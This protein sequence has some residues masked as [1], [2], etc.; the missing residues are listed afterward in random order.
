MNRTTQF[1]YICHFFFSL[2]LGN[3]GVLKNFA[4]FTPVLEP[5]FNKVADLQSPVCNFIKKDTSIPTNFAKFEICK[6]T[7]VIEQLL[8][9]F[10]TTFTFLNYDF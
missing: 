8:V 7:F 1:L 4:K 2:L 5:I 10:S 9:T 3:V 6:N